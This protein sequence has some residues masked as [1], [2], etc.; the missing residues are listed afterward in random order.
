MI[1]R[2][3][4]E[5]PNSHKYSERG[6]S[7][8]SKWRGSFAA[9]LAD[10]GPMPSANHSLDRINNNGNYEPGNCR[11]AT[12]SQQAL[13][14]RRNHLLEVDGV[15]QTISEWSELTGIN[16]RTLTNRIQHG[17]TPDRTVATPVQRGKQTPSS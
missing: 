7:V 4:P 11:W 3:R 16:Y 8:C 17:W 5:N 9:F 14:T 12:R 2:C 1:Q 13:N 15:T 10:M 6:I